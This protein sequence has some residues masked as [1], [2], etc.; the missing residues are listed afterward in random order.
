[1]SFAGGGGKSSSS[2]SSPKRVLLRL[3]P[4]LTPSLLSSTIQCTD[5]ARSNNF[6][7]HPLSAIGNGAM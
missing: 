4:I 3:D 6:V 5:F 2:L 7:S 1:M